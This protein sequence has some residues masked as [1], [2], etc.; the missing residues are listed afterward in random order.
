M[1]VAP[2]GTSGSGVWSPTAQLFE[3]MALSDEALG[4]P[5]TLTV[6]TAVVV[7]LP[8]GGANVVVLNV[9]TGPEG[10]VTLTTGGVAK[11]VPVDSFFSL[12]TRTTPITALTLTRTPGAATTVEVFLGA[13]D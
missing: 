3:Q 4:S 12:F 6:D 9:S 2:I 8:I 11:A 10:V 13:L 5:V 7:P 1:T